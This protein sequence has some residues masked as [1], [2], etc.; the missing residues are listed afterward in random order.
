MKNFIT[1]SSINK[2]RLNDTFLILGK[3]QIAGWLNDYTP[4]S[5]KDKFITPQG[6]NI[7]NLSYEE[8]FR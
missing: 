6:E 8:K 4:Q 7:E 5:I 2:K 1:P 3:Y